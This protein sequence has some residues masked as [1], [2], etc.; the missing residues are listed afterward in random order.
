MVFACPPWFLVGTVFH[1]SFPN[2]DPKTGKSNVSGVSQSYLANFA[3]IPHIE[4]TSGGRLWS[5]NTRTSGVQATSPGGT[6]LSPTSAANPSKRHRMPP[7]HCFFAPKQRLCRFGTTQFAHFCWESPSF[8]DRRGV[9]FNAK[10]FCFGGVSVL[11]PCP[12]PSPLSPWATTGEGQ[13]LAAW[14]RQKPWPTRR[15]FPR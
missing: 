10:P 14:E 4:V 5:F 11:L 12:P 15:R 6:T 1:P 7:M 2:C 8:S 9:N 3:R 13:Q